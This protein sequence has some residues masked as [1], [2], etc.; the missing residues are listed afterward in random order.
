MYCSSELAGWWV[1]SIC[2]CFDVSWSP[3]F[4]GGGLGMRVECN[5]RLSYDVMLHMSIPSSLGFT[6]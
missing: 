4:G 2:I 5:D 1:L 6:S 3:G